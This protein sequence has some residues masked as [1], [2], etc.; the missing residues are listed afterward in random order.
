M[1]ARA[2]NIMSASVFGFNMLGGNVVVSSF[3]CLLVFVFIISTSAWLLLR[4][5]LIKPRQLLILARVVSNWSLWT[6]RSF[7][8]L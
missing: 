3:T 1:S 2:E 5:S 7:S 4:L 8:F 6:A